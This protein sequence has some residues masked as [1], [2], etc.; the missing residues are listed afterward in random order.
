MGLFWDLYQQSQ[1]SDHS[2]RAGTL[3]R[4]VADLETELRQTQVLLRAVIGRL[5]E[6]LATD[7]DHDGKVG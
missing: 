2:E 7:L 1:L 3:E 5:E 4:R 6:K